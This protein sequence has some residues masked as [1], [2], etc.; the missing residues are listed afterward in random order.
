MKKY[1]YRLWTAQNIFLF[2]SVWDGV[3]FSCIVTITWKISRSIME[4]WGGN[5]VLCSLH[6][7][8]WY[9]TYLRPFP[10]FL[11]YLLGLSCL[12]FIHTYRLAPPIIGARKFCHRKL[13]CGKFRLSQS[14]NFAM[15]NF[16]TWHFSH[17]NFAS[18][19]SAAGSLTVGSFQRIPFLIYFILYLGMAS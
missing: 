15:E 1:T 6:P 19:N 16:T 11:P 14:G 9:F 12:K 17:G 4:N 13:S 8:K 5:T 2:R 3:I 18:K 7:S 10:Q